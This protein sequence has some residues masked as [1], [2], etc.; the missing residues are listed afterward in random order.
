MRSFL[1]SHI[2]QHKQHSQIKSNHG[3]LKA[4]LIINIHTI[5]KFLSLNPHRTKTMFPQSSFR[6]TWAQTCVLSHFKNALWGRN[7]LTPNKSYKI[8]RTSQH[9]ILVHWLP[10]PPS[11]GDTCQ[12]S[13]WM[14]SEEKQ[15]LVVIQT[16]IPMWSVYW[17]NSRHCR[18]AKSPMKR[19]R[20]KIKEVHRRLLQ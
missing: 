6:M 8:K 2:L 20:Q 16:K 7:S 1:P 13:P 4:N 9:F 5:F 17:G 3:K 15:Q 12:L 19:R 18:C 10:G 11:E 14:A